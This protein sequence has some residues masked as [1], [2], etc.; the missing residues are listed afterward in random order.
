MIPSK[1]TYLK[2]LRN[3]CFLFF[4]DSTMFSLSKHWE[5]AV[6]FLSMMVQRSDF[7]NIEKLLS[8]FFSSQVCVQSHKSLRIQFALTPN[9]TKHICNKKWKEK[10]FNFNL[11]SY[12]Y[13]SNFLPLAEADF[14]PF[15]LKKTWLEH[16]YL[17]IW[18]CFVVLVFEI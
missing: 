7:Q 8:C 13:F 4:N 11:K 15:Y 6:F 9:V 10:N 16:R 18:I 14:W 17:F 1:N 5:I 3:Y 12:F 2:T